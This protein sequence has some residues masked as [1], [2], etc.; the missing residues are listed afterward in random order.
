VSV[1][2]K[3]A[4][5]RWTALARSYAGVTRRPSSRMTINAQ[6]MAG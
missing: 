2:S 4:A 1:S 5:I 6:R 3:F